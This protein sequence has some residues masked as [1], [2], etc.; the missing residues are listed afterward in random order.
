MSEE[1]QEG[2]GNQRI[3]V[4]STGK[5]AIP[6]RPTAIEGRTIRRR[7]RNDMFVPDVKKP[8]EAATS[9]GLEKHHKTLG[10]GIWLQKRVAR[11]R[12]FSLHPQISPSSV[13]PTHEERSG[14]PD[15]LSTRKWLRG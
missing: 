9:S 14:N 10:I 13:K 6:L 2:E 12:V 1:S 5:G 15:L 7:P 8:E 11:F 3:M 4:L